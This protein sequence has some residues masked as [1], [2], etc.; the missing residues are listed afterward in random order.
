MN[1][2]SDVNEKKGSD[3]DIDV[4]YRDAPTVKA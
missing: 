4:R 1:E 2:G 3:G